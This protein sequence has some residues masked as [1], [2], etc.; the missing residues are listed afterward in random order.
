MCSW[1]SIAETNARNSPSLPGLRRHKRHSGQAVEK[2]LRSP[3]ASLRSPWRAHVL[4]RTLRAPG[5]TAPCIW[6]CS[7]R[8]STPWLTGPE[9]TAPLQRI[10]LVHRLLDELRGANPREEF[11]LQTQARQIFPTR[12]EQVL[13]RRLL[14]ESSDAQK[15]LAVH[16]VEGVRQQPRA[17]DAARIQVRSGGKQDV[18]L[19]KGH[20]PME[21]AAH[22]VRHLLE[23][24]FPQIARRRR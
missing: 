9:E 24:A 16:L 22:L 23:I 20:Q 5:P 3:P 10:L 12:Q 1:R 18:V 21:V 17:P 6:A 7:R 14:G 11:A 13:E 4:P 2:L 8:F 19:R 15:I